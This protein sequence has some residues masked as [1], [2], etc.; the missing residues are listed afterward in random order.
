[1]SVSPEEIYTSLQDSGLPLRPP[2]AIAEW[3]FVKRCDG[4]QAC[5]GACREGILQMGGDGYPQIDFRYGGCDFC[6]A[7]ATACTRGA[8]RRGDEGH[9]RAFRYRLAIDD[10]CL[11]VAGEP[12]RT[13][14]GFCDNY[15]IRFH[16][17]AQGHAVPV[18]LDNLC[19]G[20]GACVGPCPTG[21]IQLSRPKVPGQP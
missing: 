16:V 3:A 21:S 5:V 18:V 12:C 7:C 4:C 10:R 19:N 15:A 11:A 6:G 2:W 1:M 14:E 20:C 13:C 17:G 8:L 9:E